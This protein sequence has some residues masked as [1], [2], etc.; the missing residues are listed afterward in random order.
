MEKMMRKASIV[1]SDSS[2]ER[3]N[4]VFKKGARKSIHPSMGGGDGG[5][6]NSVTVSRKSSQ[7]LGFPPKIKLQNTYRIAPE[8]HEKFKP[9]KIEPRV[10]EILEKALKDQKYDH[11]RVDRQTKELTQEIMREARSSIL[12]SRYK[13]VSHVAIGEFKGAKLYHKQ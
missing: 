12:S 10:Y 1:N 11:S 4:T 9:F 5:K 3:R 6:R 2:Y 8:E 13:V 7:D